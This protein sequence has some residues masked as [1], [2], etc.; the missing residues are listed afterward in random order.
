MDQRPPSRRGGWVFYDGECAMCT[1]LAARWRHTLREHGFELIPLQ[2]RGVAE[3]LGVTPDELLSQVWLL[4]YDGRVLGGADACIYLA[5]QIR[6]IWWAWVLIAV[7]A[8]PGGTR[9]IRW[10]YHWIAAHRR[11]F[12]GTC[13]L[14]DP[15]AWPPEADTPRSPTRR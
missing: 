12:G 14:G 10:V 6:S 5:R 13:T 11:Y 4:A 7:G 8:L 15:G 1:A 9:V 3:R 2:A